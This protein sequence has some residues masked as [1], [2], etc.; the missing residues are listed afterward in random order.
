MHANKSGGHK[1]Q[2]LCMG[3]DEHN[4]YERKARLLDRAVE[5]A[6]EMDYQDTI[7]RW[8][9]IVKVGADGGS[10]SLLGRKYRRDEWQ[11]IC[12]TDE[13]TLKDMLSES[14][15]KG[16]HGCLTTDPVERWENGLKLLREYPWTCLVPIY[17]HPEFSLLVMKEVESCRNDFYEPD[18]ER[19]GAASCGMN[20]I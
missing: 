5:W 15:R 13:H 6:K 14:D 18:L 9:L 19:W 12:V 17:I 4:R 11:F 20:D 16:V 2:V 3:N 8:Q 10:L 7:S 1:K